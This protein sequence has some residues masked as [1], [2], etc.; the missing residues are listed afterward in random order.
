MTEIPPPLKDLIMQDPRFEEIYRKMELL[1]AKEEAS[2]TAVAETQGQKRTGGVSRRHVLGAGILALAGAFAFTRQ[3]TDNDVPQ[4]A[5]SSTASIDI[6]VPEQPVN[7]FQ[8]F[9][10]PFMI[11]ALKRRQERVAKDPEYAKRIDQE[12]NENRINIVLFGYGEEHGDSY[13]DYGGT[14][15]VL[16]YDLK[17]SQIGV[18]HF[19][20]DIRVP[21]LERLFPNDPLENKR[22]RS[23][24][25][26]GGFPLLQTVCE[27]MTGLVA[28][29]QIVLKDTVIMDAI[30]QLTDGKLE[31]TVPKDHDTGPYRLDRIQYGDGFINAGTQEMN[32][33]LLMRYIL[34]EDKNPGGKEDERSYRKNDVLVALNQKIREKV[35]KDPLVLKKALD[36]VRK[37]IDFKNAQVDFDLNLLN[38]GGQ[39]F[40]GFLGALTKAITTQRTDTQ[41]P[42]MNKQ[43]QHVFHD[44][45]FGD[46]GVT[47][48]HNIRDNPPAGTR[49]DSPE[50]L[51]DIRKNRLPDWVLIPDGGNP[52]AKD[53]VN[54]YW[55]S[56][57]RL[58]KNKLMAAA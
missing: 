28:D 11:E 16:S 52:Y 7:L 3:N 48:V 9:I 53:L 2:Q 27:D 18:I 35:R 4:T 36:L 39:F 49:D 41:L 20:R 54:D 37:E 55:G 44:F 34:A 13:E 21:E 5:T 8:E 19:S 51:E 17:S 46:G 42:E 25:K 57:R 47:R 56:V 23:I 24:F 15:T 12:L 29:F 10:K 32:T 6:S 40:S 26:K 33:P 43:K 45:V 22:V 50:L 14:P 58:V 1:K 38:L 30:N 31:I